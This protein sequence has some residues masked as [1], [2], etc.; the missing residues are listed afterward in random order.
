MFKDW[1][2][3]DTWN[4]I[5]MLLVVAAAIGG[6]IIFFA[7]KN[8]DYYYISHSGAQNTSTCV[9]AHWTW[10]V[11][12]IAFCTDDAAKAADFTLKAN[13]GLKSK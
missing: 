11:D 4:I 9:Y 13:Q 12:E 5:G 3:Q 2:M 8:V 1:E 10:H 7:P 6:G